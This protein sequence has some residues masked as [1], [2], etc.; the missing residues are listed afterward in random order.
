MDVGQ[1]NIL[2][3]KKRNKESA[4]ERKK[5]SKDCITWQNTYNTMIYN[6]GNL[7]IHKNKMYED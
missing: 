2:V 3:K 1:I 4:C 6:Y 5:F 7:Y